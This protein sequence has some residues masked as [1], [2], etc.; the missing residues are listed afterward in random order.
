MKIAELSVR[1]LT[2]SSSPSSH[3]GAARAFQFY[4]TPGAGVDYDFKGKHHVRAYWIAQSK[5]VRA[6][7]L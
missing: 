6:M 2:G 7:P 3:P 5:A 1:R 4:G